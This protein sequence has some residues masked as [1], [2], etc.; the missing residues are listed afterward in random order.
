MRYEG[1]VEVAFIGA[2]SFSVTL[3][4]KSILLVGSRFSEEATYLD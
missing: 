2:A 4:G 3:C 1:S